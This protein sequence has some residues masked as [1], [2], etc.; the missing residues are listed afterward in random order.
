MKTKKEV[1]ILVCLFL[2]IFL[3]SCEDK[4]D[5]F[6]FIE[7]FTAT[8]S[9]VTS[10]KSITLLWIVSNADRAEID[11]GI[12]GVELS[13]SR[14]IALNLPG[15]YDYTLT[16]VKGSHTSTATVSVTCS[17]I[18]MKLQYPQEGLYHSAFVFQGNEGWEDAVTADEV[19]AFE[20]LVGKQTVWAYFSNNWFSG[21]SFPADGVNTLKGLG[22]VPF[23]RMMARHEDAWENPGGESLYTMQNIIDGKF[24]TELTAWAA[25]ARNCGVPLLVEFGTEVN[26]DWFPWNGS[27]HGAGTKN[28][29]GDPDYPDGPERFRDAYRHIIHIFRNEGADNVTW[30]FHVNNSSFPEE[31][32]NRYS[33]YYPGDDYIDWIGV[34]VY[35]PQTPDSDYESF[36]S[37]MDECYPK[38]CALSAVK[39]IALLEFGVCEGGWDKALWIADA[40]ASLSGGKYP[41][42]KAVSWW[43][44]KW[45]NSDGSWSDL[46]VNS[47]AGSL[48]AYK[49]GVSNGIFIVTPVFSGSK[50][51]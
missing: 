3:C 10:G 15:V 25:A 49:N 29:Y 11:N 31:E 14:I 28:G 40:F 39:P 42:L 36:T 13:G 20:T 44:E 2:L 17:S 22:R 6:P 38:L 48:N 19:T 4:D 51:K 9:S 43:N 27:Y 7:S 32:W 12:G 45:E 47:S 5:E 1:F 35:G 18:E 50:R 8:P 33:Y 21:I 26:G 34:S 41:R 23:I 30:F 24:D 16:A 46:T 37:M